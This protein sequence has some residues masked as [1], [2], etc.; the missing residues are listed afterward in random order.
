MTKR[1]II[2]IVSLFVITMLGW[3]ILKKVLQSKST[4]ANIVEQLKRL[5]EKG[6]DGLYTLE[7]GSLNVDPDKMQII[8]YGIDLVPNEAVYKSLRTKNR[9][10]ND[11]FSLNAEK[12]IINNITPANFIVS[13]SIILQ[14]IE[15]YKPSI[16]ILHEE[17]VAATKELSPKDSI[18]STHSIYDLLKDQVGKIAIDSILLLGLDLKHINKSRN[19]DT[20]SFLNLHLFAEDFLLDET[21]VNDVSRFLFTNNLIVKLTDF[22]SSLKN[23]IYTIKFDTLQLAITKYSHT[24]LTNFKLEPLYGENEY[25][26]NISTQL[27]RFEVMMEQVDITNFNYRKF[28]NEHLIEGDS[29]IL[30]NGLFNIFKDRTKNFD[31]KTRLGKYP[32][33][34][35]EKAGMPINFS[36]CKI[37]NTDLVYREKSDKTEETGEIN[38][39]YCNAVI[40]PINST[41]ESGK[42]TPIIMHANSRFA[43]VTPLTAKFVLHPE[44]KDGAFEVSGNFGKIDLKILN[45][46]TIPL[47]EIRVDTGIVE[48]L[49]FDIKGNDFSST[50][51]LNFIYKGVKVSI[52]GKD[53]ANT[54]KK[55]GLLSFAANNFLLKSDN[56]NRAQ[57]VVVNYKRD[58]DKSM[59]NLIWK[60]IFAGMKTL[61]GAGG[62]GKDKDRIEVIKKQ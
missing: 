51:E 62:L 43:G 30:A 36:V 32:H 6:S 23:S 21:S 16:S 52:L 3:G 13:R 47:G 40:A 24:R 9:V 46:T 41:N 38:F 56:L 42:A 34:L 26:K 5:V 60:G 1:V 11:L 39:K 27:E 10:G 54:F 18:I 28:L 57:R 19:N 17:N 4:S 44:S 58:T 29:L 55:K 50:T 59:F 7:V 61:S 2:I 25:S 49:Q 33:Q 15:I 12:L 22:Q 53:D 45:K 37:I 8:L 14:S 31:G 35:L 20:T 48:K